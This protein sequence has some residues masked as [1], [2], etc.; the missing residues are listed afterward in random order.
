MTVLECALA[1]KCFRSPEDAAHIIKAGG[2]KING[3]L[4]TNPQE[5]LVY[6]QHILINNITIIRVGK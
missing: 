1:A 5:A 4:C 3:T 2:F 6:G